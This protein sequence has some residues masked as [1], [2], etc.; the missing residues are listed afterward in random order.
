MATFIT[1]AL[2]PGSSNADIYDT[3]KNLPILTVADDDILWS[4]IARY[5]PNQ[6]LP[7]RRDRLKWKMEVAVK[8]LQLNDE[9][10]S[11][12]RTG[13]TWQEAR[14]RELKSDHERL[15]LQIDAR[16]EVLR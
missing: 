13:V 12:L 8:R 2:V 11:K 15:R 7:D 4:Q 16:G 3:Y 1:L 6:N 5:I 14:L 10:K 9:T